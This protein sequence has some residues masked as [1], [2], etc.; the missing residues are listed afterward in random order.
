MDRVTLREAF[1]SIEDVTDEIFDA[2]EQPEVKVINKKKLN[3]S[4]KSLK[5]SIYTIEINGDIYCDEDGNSYRFNSNEEAQDFID[6]HELEG[7]TIT[8]QYG[9]A[10][11]E[12]LDESEQLDEKLP[13]DLAKAYRTAGDSERIGFTGVGAKYKDYDRGGYVT[14]KNKDTRRNVK[15]DYENSQYTEITPEQAL[16]A[17]KDGNISKL[18]ILI[19]G[20]LVQFR[21]DGYPLVG[22][23]LGYRDENIYKNKA[24]KEIR[25]TR[26]MPFNHLINIADKIYLTDED[27]HA[28]GKGGQEF[29]YETRQLVDIPSDDV[30]NKRKANRIDIEDTG[31]HKEKFKSIYRTWAN[32]NKEEIK[33]Y[34]NKLVELDKKWEAGDISKN[35]YEKQKASLEQSLEYVT[36]RDRNAS[37]GKI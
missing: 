27:E 10:K 37:Y 33:D 25:D 3:E 21:N 7:A 17:K 34:K 12:S 22:P 1:K 23:E 16:Q 2:F 29:D 15:T 32:D 24:G 13:K 36:K 8:R 11:D 6:E 18:R 4:K 30:Y 19:N 5:E 20:D 35:D 14:L 31:K 9:F 28:I 26:R